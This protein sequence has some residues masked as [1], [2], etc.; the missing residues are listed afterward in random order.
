MCLFGKYIKNKKYIA[1]KKNKG[2]IPEIKDKRTEWVEVKCGKCIE[3]VKQETNK[4]RVRMME[5]IRHNKNGIFVTMTFSNEEITKLY[6]EVKGITGYEKDNKV[7]KIAVRRFR[8]R[9]RKEKGKSIRHWLVTELGQKNTEHLHIH[10]ILWTNEKKEDIAKHWKYGKVDIGEKANEETINYTVKYLHKKDS[11]HK[12]YKSIILTSPGI[13]A[14]Y[15]ERYDSKLNKYN[16]EKTKETYTT[17]TGHNIAL[18][19]YWKNKLYSEEEK[20]RLWI[21]KLDKAEKWIC[22]EKVNT[23]NEE[24]YRK[25]LEFYR[26]KNRRLGY[27]DDRK[28]IERKIYENNERRKKQ[29]ERYKK[30]KK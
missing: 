30:E 24:E 28:N 23:N 26:E 6:K 25:T 13:G 5:D 12:E 19:A 14:K 10:G 9:W 16:G 20:E 17:R 1:N 8:E 2:I 21:Q 29:L 3:C 27:G 15:I 11:K 4:W 22:G 7:A 18:P